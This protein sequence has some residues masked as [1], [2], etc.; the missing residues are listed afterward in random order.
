MISSPIYRIGIGYDVHQLVKGQKLII[1]GVDI[2]H[3]FGLSGYSDADVLIHAIADAILGALAEGDIGKH[4]PS[5]KP[6]FK[7]MPGKVLLSHVFNIMRKR[8]YRINNLDATV[9]AQKPKITEFIPQ[10]RNNLSSI[11][12][13]NTDNISIKATTTDKLGFVGRGEGIAAEVVVMLVDVQ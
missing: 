5:G 7:D 2:Q 13:S 3:P 10:M 11:L 9:I 12:F 6:E 8:G 4:F 1:G